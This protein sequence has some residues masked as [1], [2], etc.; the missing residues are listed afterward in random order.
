MDVKR[1]ATCRWAVLSRRTN[2]TRF[3]SVHVQ[4]GRVQSMTLPE[5]E[6]DLSRFIRRHAFLGLPSF[7]WQL[8]RNTLTY[9]FPSTSSPHYP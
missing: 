6:I 2:S 9:S 5:D 1:T 8:A 3:G 7:R 4:A